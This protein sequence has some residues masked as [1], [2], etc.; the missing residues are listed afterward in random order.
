MKNIYGDD[1]GEPNWSDFWWEV[2][3]VV[4]ILFLL[5]GWIFVK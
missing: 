5:L 3:T 2:L 4:I 1:D